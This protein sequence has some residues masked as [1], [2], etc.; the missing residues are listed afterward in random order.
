MTPPF[1]NVEKAF[2]REVARE[3]L[4]ET[5]PDIIALHKAQCE[6]G[7]TV[8]RWRNRGWGMIAAL[9]GLGIAAGAGGGAAF[10]AILSLAKG[11][12]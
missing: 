1:S 4:S 11:N 2:I 10:G 8:E 3:I 7:H 6:H 9:I 12:P 5:L